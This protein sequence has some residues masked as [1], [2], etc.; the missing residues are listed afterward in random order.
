M[1]ALVAAAAVSAVV[2]SGFAAETKMPAVPKHPM[3]IE[4]KVQGMEK[5]SGYPSDPK[6]LFKLLDDDSNG[7]LSRAEWNNNIMAV[8]FIRDANHD[9][10]LSKDELPGL[11][12][13]LFDAADLNGDGFLSGYEFNQAKFTQFAAADVDKAG[14]ITEDEFIAFLDSLK[15]GN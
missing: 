1:I 10:K 3:K 15:T 13:E 8:F 4:P 14:S 11:R 7:E 5:K 9:L 6:A 2:G 12:P